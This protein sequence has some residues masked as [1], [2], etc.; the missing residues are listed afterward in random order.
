MA[1]LTVEIGSVECEASKCR[2]GPM[3]MIYYLD[4]RARDLSGW[5]PDTTITV[6]LQAVLG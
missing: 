1:I 3:E 2:G 6:Q 4:P 5:G